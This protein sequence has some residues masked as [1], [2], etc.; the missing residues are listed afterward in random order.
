MASLM[1]KEL[2]R[3]KGT[4]ED[5]SPSLSTLISSA[6]SHLFVMQTLSR[7]SILAITVAFVELKNG[8]FKS[9]ITTFEMSG[10][11]ANLDWL[12]LTRASKRK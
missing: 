2:R 12:G 8:L 6:C 10:Y 5:A 4:L 1:G 9:S 7:N 11:N 3:R